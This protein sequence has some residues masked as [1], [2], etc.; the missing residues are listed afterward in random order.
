MVFYAVNDRAMVT[1]K[2]AA[3]FSIGPATTPE[4]DKGFMARPANVCR[5]YAA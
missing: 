5:L 3:Y 1:A 4:R 2:Q